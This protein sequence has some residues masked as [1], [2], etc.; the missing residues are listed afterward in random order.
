M[1]Q[2]RSLGGGRGIRDE[3][4]NWKGGMCK[5]IFKHLGLVGF[6]QV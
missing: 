5:P 2:D 3:G 4:A 6:T 1:G